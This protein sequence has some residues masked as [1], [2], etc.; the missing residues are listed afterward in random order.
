MFLQ[1]A[2]SNNDNHYLGGEEGQD[3]FDSGG[4]L[5]LVDQIPPVLNSVQ[6]VLNFLQ[7]SAVAA[8]CAPM[9]SR[10]PMHSG[11]FEWR[12][13]PLAEH[14]TSPVGNLRRSSPG[15][16]RHG[17]AR[18][19]ASCPGERLQLIHCPPMLR[20]IWRSLKMLRTV[21][22]P[23]HARVG[24]ALRNAW[25]KISTR[26]RCCGHPGQPGC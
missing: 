18:G 16:C 15:L 5:V 1:G 22:G 4:R 20:S 12:P 9:L 25:I 10:G 11:V 7:Q 19:R 21:P 26:S 6:P 2:L 23:W 13:D 17:G 3:L 14:Q 24:M 8:H